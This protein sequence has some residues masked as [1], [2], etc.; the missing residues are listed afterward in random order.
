FLHSVR[1]SV[2]W[3][4]VV[5]YANRNCQLGY[6]PDPTVD[7]FKKGGLGNGVTTVNTTQWNNFNGRYPFV[8]CGI[9][10]SLG[11]NTGTVDYTVPGWEIMV[12]VPT[13]RGLENIFGHIWDWTDGINVRVQ[14]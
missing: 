3:L 9:T 6:D 1:K 14:S 10:N 4:Y 11:N 13:Y 8:P 2:L 7:G 5:E 12:N